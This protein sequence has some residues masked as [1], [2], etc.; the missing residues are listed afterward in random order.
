M[1][2]ATFPITIKIEIEI[3][4]PVGFSGNLE[5]KWTAVGKTDLSGKATHETSILEGRC[6]ALP[7]PVS[8]VKIRSVRHYL[9]M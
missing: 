1:I 3:L 5:P 7:S 4:I 9:A 2:S 8:T 6:L